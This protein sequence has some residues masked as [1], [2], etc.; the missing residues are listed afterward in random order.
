MIKLKK[1]QIE[2]A[3]MLTKIAVDSEATWGFDDEFMNLFEI[4][5]DVTPDFI[6][7]QLVY[8]LYDEDKCVGFFGIV[9]EEL[10]SI[11]EFFYISA[12]FIRKGYGKIMW[13]KLVEV[14]KENQISLIEFV[15]SPEA[16]PFYQS[17]GAILME[18]VISMVMPKRE[19]PKMRFEIR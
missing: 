9:K 17:R 6:S 16:M 5:Y 3:E 8:E 12:D 2:D 15:T 10:I 11:L 1:A 14:C 4:L 19:I 18:N 7:S 13:E